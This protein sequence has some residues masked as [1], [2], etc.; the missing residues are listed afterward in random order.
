MSLQPVAHARRSFVWRKLAALGA[1]F[2]D[3]HHAAVA[4][5]FDDHDE[6]RARTMGLADLSPLP[7]IGFKGR[8]ALAA[9]RA[10]GLSFETMPNRAF[11]QADGT[12]IGILG[13]GEA[14]L[15]GPLT[16]SA[17]KL[18]LLERDGAFV[19]GLR[20]YLAPRAESHFWFKVT[21]QH[22][23]SMFAKLCGIDLRPHRFA[24]LEIA[25]T[26]AAK[27]S[28]IVIRHDLGRTLAYD[29]LADSASAGYFWDVLMDAM[30]EFA[31]G[32]VGL[33]SLRALEHEASKPTPG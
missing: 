1:A 23:P 15:L 5:R 17:T 29:L 7:R 27:A 30:A 21:G 18:S 24:D 16:G 12:L 4:A 10:K 25:Q 28:A 8:D 20:C 11:R 31:G 13:P 32:P 26:S 14:L 9:L 2:A 19:P 22:A 6:A 3:V 33:T